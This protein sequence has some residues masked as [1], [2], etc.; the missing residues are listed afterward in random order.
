M[1]TLTQAKYRRALMLLV[2]FHILII[3]ASNYLVQLPFQLFSYHTTWGA[4][5]FPFVYL[6]T[7]LTVRVFGQQAARGIIL[8]A[9]IPALVVSYLVGVLFHQGQLQAFSALAEWNSFVFRI[10]FASFVAYLIGQ[11][12][13]ITVFAKLRQ[14][15]AWWVAPAASTLIGNLVDTLVFFSVAFYAS[16]DAF[17]ATHWPEIATVDYAFKL[18]VSLGLFLPAYGVLL[19]ILQDKI[20]LNGGSDSDNV[21]IQASK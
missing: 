13:D 19:K 4:F 3:C 6:A 7:D 15:K 5:S 17:M 14:A 16:N 18:I 20:L 9:M 12:M 8:K 2:S 1:L 10:A 21:I 11:L